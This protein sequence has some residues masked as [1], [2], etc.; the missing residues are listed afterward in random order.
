M[1]DKS[2]RVNQ[3]KNKCGGGGKIQRQKH[4]FQKS[5]TLNPLLSKTSQNATNKDDAISQHKH[6]YTKKQ[7]KI[8][9]FFK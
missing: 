6:F 2:K 9:D 3:S 8:Y 5:K 1:G 7:Q 4:R